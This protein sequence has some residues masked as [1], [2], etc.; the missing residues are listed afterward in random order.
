MD[1]T[2]LAWDNPPVVVNALVTAKV[3]GKDCALIGIRN[4]ENGKGKIE[5]IGGFVEIGETLEEALR[6]EVREETEC[7]VIRLAY[8]GS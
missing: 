5:L 6:R 7:E 3:N 8:F 2:P 1:R 4:Q